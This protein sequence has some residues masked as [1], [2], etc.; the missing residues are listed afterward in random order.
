LPRIRIAPWQLATIYAVFIVAVS[1]NVLFVSLFERLDIY[2]LAGLGFLTTIVVLMVL[3]LVAIFLILGVGRALKPVIAL[4]LI[5]SSILAYFCN[6]MGVVFHQE[7]LLNIAETVRDNNSAE[8][9]EL[10]SMPLI[11]HVL[12]FGI[13]PTVL[14]TFVQI[15]PRRFLAEFG[16]RAVV[17]ATGLILLAGVTLP[18]YRHVTYFARDNRDLRLDITP[19]FPLIS[20]VKLID[21]RLHPKSPF[22][23]I[24]ATA[25]QRSNRTKRSIGIMVVG[26]TARADRF[27]LGGYARKTNPLLEEIPDVLFAKASS[28]GTSTLFS[29]PC[30][31]SM[32]GR[33]S[34]EPDEA[35]SESNVLDILTAA[36]IKT[37]WIDNNSSCKKVCNRIENLN[38]RENPD[39]SSEFYDEMGYFDEVLLQEI[40]AYLGKDGPDTLIVLH[41]LG[42]H[43]PAYG[44]R[45]PSR[46]GVFKPFCQQS[47][48]TDCTVEEVTNAYDNSIYYTDYLLSQLIQ[49]LQSRSDEV[50]TFLF[51]A[52]DHGESLGENGVYLHGLPYAIAPL[53]QKSVPF[54][55]WTSPQFR[56]GRAGG[57]ENAMSL[58]QEGLSHDNIS[59]TLLGIYDVTASSYRR[60]L[61]ILDAADS[62]ARSYTLASSRK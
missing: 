57:L 7:M 56:D 12:I 31:F 41:T 28:C 62:P 4:F 22:R 49:R 55:V 2:S 5:V 45:F 24:D 47:S 58:P 35:S 17:L 54:I 59:H 38:L 53:A 39:E 51:Y 29:V 14:L 9:L 3:V 23:V 42:S 11:R 52:S 44:R 50:D 27:S 34:Y 16:V 6:E 33:T 10:A 60:D 21:R 43:G 1:N 25:F 61:D 46:F 19:I 30:M 20:A 18:N 40:D 48:P 13:A 15:Q 32:R 37:V 8:A 26:E 36:G